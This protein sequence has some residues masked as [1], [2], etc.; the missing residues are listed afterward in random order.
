MSYAK[1]LCAKKCKNAISFEEQ[2]IFVKGTVL[3]CQIV[4]ILLIK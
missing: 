1:Y 2:D 4:Q 3:G